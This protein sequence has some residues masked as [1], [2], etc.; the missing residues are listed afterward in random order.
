MQSWH[1]IEDDVDDRQRREL[2]HQLRAPQTPPHPEAE[3][4]ADW[5]WAE[6]DLFHDSSAGGS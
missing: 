2:L 3:A 5:P 4:D 6:G 1:D